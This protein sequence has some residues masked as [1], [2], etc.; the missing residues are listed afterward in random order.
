MVGV[1]LILFSHSIKCEN[2][3]LFLFAKEQVTDGT[4]WP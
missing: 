4:P 3:H 1:T 2:I